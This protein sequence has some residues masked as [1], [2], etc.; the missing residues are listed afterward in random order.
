MDR[1]SQSLLLC[2]K[3]A[4]QMTLS[5]REVVINCIYFCSLR[6][7]RLWQTSASQLSADRRIPCL[8]LCCFSFLLW[9]CER[10]GGCLLSAFLLV[11]QF[12]HQNMEK[13][14]FSDWLIDIITD[15]IIVVY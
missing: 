2:S 7:G 14:P 5:R 3:A 10:E 13:L 4:S 9:E 6:S 8:L 12:G 1:I 15:L 11:S